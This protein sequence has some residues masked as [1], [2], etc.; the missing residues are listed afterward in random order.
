MITN[1]H[2][3]RL[4]PHPDNPRSDLGD[5][6]DLAASI[7]RSGLLQNLTVVPHPDK[8]DLYRI[9]IGHRRF[10]ASGIAGL[11]ELPCSIE[12]MSP[13]DQVATMMAENMQRNDL[14]IAD[15]VH[16][17]QTMLDLGES[18]KTIAGKIGMS[19]STVRKRATIA[20]LPRKEM[21]M[22]AGKGAT[23]MDLLDVAQLE[24]PEAQA[25]VLESFGTN[26]FAYAVRRAKDDEL[27][28]KFHKAVMPEIRAKFP[29]ITEFSSE[30][31]AYSGRWT[32]I[33]RAGHRAADRDPLPEPEPGEK[34]R[35]SD[36][37]YGMAIYM[38]NKEWVAQKAKDKDF[39]AWMRD[40]KETAKRLNEEAFELRAAFVRKYRLGTRGEYLNFYEL[41][42]KEMMDWYGFQI[43]T[44]YCHHSGW[45]NIAIRRMLAIPQEADRDERETLE[46]ELE[47]R[48]VHRA[49]FLLAWALCGGITENV[50][51]Y[52]G[53][54]NYYDGK[55]RP[56]SGLEN[57]YRLLAA[58][59]YQMSDFERSLEK[60]THKFFKEKWK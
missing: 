44:G 47:R 30:T 36:W 48:G 11:E 37:G 6:T 31:E 2:R 43:K 23:L 49:S 16:G 53:W 17:V 33:W 15:Q 19:E 57:Q 45:V 42:V 18:V 28:I 56:S 59:G 52:D 38:E 7:E 27:A 40:R 60:K 51:P 35:L 4:E 21:Q 14:T 55:W 20:A 5:L 26:N 1:I 13:A 50:E 32:E 12:E 25:K 39:N 34:Y 29:N 8:P 24:S 9:V 10:A 3:S 58:L 41:C 46:H 54:C 22:A